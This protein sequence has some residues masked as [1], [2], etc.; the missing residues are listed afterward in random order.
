MP[1]LTSQ[2]AR[3]FLPTASYGLD[4]PGTAYRMDSIPIRMRAVLPRRRPTDE[5]VLNRILEALS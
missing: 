5:E 3:V 1:N 2:I 4:A